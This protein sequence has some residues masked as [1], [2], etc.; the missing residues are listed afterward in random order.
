MSNSDVPDCS[1]HKKVALD[2]VDDNPSNSRTVTEC[3]PIVSELLVQ[4]RS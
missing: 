1:Q 4:G 3:V 2:D